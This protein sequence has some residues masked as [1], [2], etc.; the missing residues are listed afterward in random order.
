MNIIDICI[1]IT[2]YK[3]RAENIYTCFATITGKMVAYEPHDY[4]SV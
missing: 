2:F 3:Y 4:Y 1:K